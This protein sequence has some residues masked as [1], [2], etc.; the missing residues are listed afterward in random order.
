MQLPQGIHLTDTQ[1]SQACSSHRAY[2]SQTYILDRRAASTGLKLTGRRLQQQPFAAGDAHLA[3][4][5]LLLNER[6]KAM[7]ERKPNAAST[8]EQAT[9]TKRGSEPNPIDTTGLS[10]LSL[11]GGGV[12]GVST[13]YTLKSVMDRLNHE[14]K[15]ANLASVKPCEVFDLIGGAST[16]G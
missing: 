11:D 9:S 4:D 1:L 7:S 8:M 15:A 14:R 16:S 10:L 6:H 5:S 13:L 3:L 2:I 12:R